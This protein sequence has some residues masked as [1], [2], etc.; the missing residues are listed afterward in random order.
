[1][2]FDFWKDNSLFF[3]LSETFFF[4]APFF[5]KKKVFQYNFLKALYLVQ[6]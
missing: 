5:F 4:Y 6:L 3:T 2:Q 1:M